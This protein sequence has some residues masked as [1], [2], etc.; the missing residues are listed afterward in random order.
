MQ[1]ISFKEA[2]AA[3]VADEVAV[4][5]TGPILMTQVFLPHLMK[6]AASPIVNVTSGIAY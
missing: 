5:L 2:P 3:G 1:N 6:Q 4:N